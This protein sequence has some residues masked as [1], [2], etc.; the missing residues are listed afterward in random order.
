MLRKSRISLHRLLLGIHRAEVTAHH[1][2][3]VTKAS[4][5]SVVSP[6]TV[7]GFYFFRFL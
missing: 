2:K 5:C 7:K 6:V 3:H 1:G 4:K